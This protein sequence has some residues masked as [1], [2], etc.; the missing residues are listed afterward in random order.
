MSVDRKR[1]VLSAVLAELEREASVIG[2]SARDAWEGATHEEN[3]A[4]HAKDMRATEA[5]YVAMGQSARL[6]E[7]EDAVAKVASLALSPWEQDVAADV[8]ALVT[9]EDDSEDASEPR[10]AVM[11]V[12]AGGGVTVLDGGS[13]VRAVTPQAPLGAAVLGALAGDTVTVG[14]RSFEVVAIE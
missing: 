11:L 3:R 14:A 13:R 2:R 4:E 1:R 7:L 8:G 5:S 12:P 10:I 9:L 6:R